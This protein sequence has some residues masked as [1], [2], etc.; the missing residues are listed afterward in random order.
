MVKKSIASSS[1]SSSSSSSLSLFSF[2]SVVRKVS[3]DH[4][5]HANSLA[6]VCTPDDWAKIKSMTTPQSQP[7]SSSSLSVMMNRPNLKHP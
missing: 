5:T 4:N 7:Q 6:L 2:A 1:S 3:Q